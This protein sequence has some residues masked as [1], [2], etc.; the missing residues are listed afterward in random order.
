VAR[1]LCPEVGEAIEWLGSLGLQARMTGSGSA[2]FALLPPG[3]TLGQAPA[4]WAQAG[5]VV[6]EC[7]KMEVHP[8]V[9]WASSDDSV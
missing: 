2:V 4:H 7:G 9:G 6:R 3:K 1:Q 5:W 8:L